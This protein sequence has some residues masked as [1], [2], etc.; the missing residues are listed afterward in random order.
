MMKV[1]LIVPLSLFALK[2]KT[3]KYIYSPLVTLSCCLISLFSRWEA[4]WLVCAGYLF[5][6]I[7]D[8]FLAH[9]SIHKNSYL[10]GIAGFFFAHACFLSYTLVHFQLSIM[11]AIVSAL[12]L[13]PYGAYAF[14]CLLPALSGIAMRIA[15][16]MYMVISIAVFSC[17]FSMNVPALNKYVYLS[18]IGMILFSDTVISFSDFLGYRKWDKWILPTY[19]LCHILVCASVII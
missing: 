4:Q 1:L 7:G 17:S 5:S 12:L 10:F 19:Y 8:F 2:L 18:G 6:V 3:G 15:V 14:R 16:T 11:T 13:I 9:K